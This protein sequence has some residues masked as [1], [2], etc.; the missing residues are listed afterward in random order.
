MK[1]TWTLKDVSLEEVA[2]GSPDDGFSSRR[3]R[4]KRL[5]QAR[6]PV[7]SNRDGLPCAQLRFRGDVPIGPPRTSRTTR[8]FGLEMNLRPGILIAADSLCQFT[9]T[10]RPLWVSHTLS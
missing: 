10:V 2:P 5:L 9:V 6:H 4:P 8:L 3:F 1:A 7:L